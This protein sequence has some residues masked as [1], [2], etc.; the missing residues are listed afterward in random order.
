M[1]LV[2]MLSAVSLS[3]GCCQI[4]PLEIPVSP[5]ETYEVTISAALSK[6]DA[7]SANSVATCYFSFTHN[8][9]EVP[10][11]D[12]LVAAALKRDDYTVM[13]FLHPDCANQELGNHRWFLQVKVP[14]LATRMRIECKP[15]NLLVHAQFDPIQVVR[16]P[17]ESLQVDNRVPIRKNF[18]LIDGADALTAYGRIADQSARA[19][20]TVNVEVWVRMAKVG[21]YACPVL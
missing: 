6:S 5:D 2:A 19:V 16:L 4:L 13:E 3:A 1:V 10:A 11:E 14:G 20:V 8:G 17:S 21:R 7:E 9:L 18:R 15:R 12:S